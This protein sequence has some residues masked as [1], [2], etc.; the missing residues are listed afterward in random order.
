MNN[1][2]D[3]KVRYLFLI[4]INFIFSGPLSMTINVFIAQGKKQTYKNS[5]F[6]TL[7]GWGD[8]GGGGLKWSHTIFI[9]FILLYLAM[10]Y[11]NV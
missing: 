6:K 7:K 2:D 11:L 1:D 10:E 3:D 8:W 5:F 4:K 9:L